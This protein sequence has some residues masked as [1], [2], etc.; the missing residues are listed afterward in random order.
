M[1]KFFLLFLILILTLS[2]TACGPAGA[3]PGTSPPS[4]VA[5]A[6]I[7]EDLMSEDQAILIVLS[8]IEGA[9]ASDITS[10]ALDNEDSRWQYEGEIVHDGKEYEFEVDAQ[11]G[12]ILGWIIDD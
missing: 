11:N 9:K 12:N 5:N 3:G 1:R 4:D 6:D 7:P 2:F 8:R 10:F